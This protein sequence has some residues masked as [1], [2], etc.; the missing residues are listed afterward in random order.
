MFN[1][2]HIQGVFHFLMAAIGLSKRVFHPTE[3]FTTQSCTLKKEK[4]KGLM[5]LQKVVDLG[6]LLNFLFS[7]R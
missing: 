1:F 3:N 7:I 6:Q 4:K 5:Y 2:M